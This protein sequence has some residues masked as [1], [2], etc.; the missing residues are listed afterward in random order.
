[1]DIYD[2][3]V[4]KDN[5]LRQIDVD[6]VNKMI[7]ELKTVPYSDTQADKIVSD[8]VKEF[9]SGKKTAEEAAKL[10]QNKMN[11]YLGE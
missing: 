1:M 11:I 5:I 7:G 2:L 9:F 10:I 6:L 3:V 8:E 4:P